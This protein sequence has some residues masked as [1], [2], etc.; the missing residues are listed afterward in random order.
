MTYLA[1][2]TNARRIRYISAPDELWYLRNRILP[3]IEAARSH[4]RAW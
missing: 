3:E 4:R 1:I 2:Y